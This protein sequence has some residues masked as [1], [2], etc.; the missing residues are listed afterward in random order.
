MTPI[1]KA[2]NTESVMSV[3][4]RHHRFR[5]W[6]IWTTHRHLQI[7]LK[8]DRRLRVGTT[9]YEEPVLYISKR[10]N[11]SISWLR[12]IARSYYKT[13]YATLKH[14]PGL[15]WLD[16]TG[17]LSR[18]CVILGRWLSS[19]VIIVLNTLRTRQIGHH[20]T[21]DIVRFV[22]CHE[23]CCILIQIALLNFKGIWI[24]EHAIV[25]IRNVTIRRILGGLDRDTVI[26]SPLPWYFFCPGSADDMIWSVARNFFVM[27]A[28]FTRITRLLSM[29][30]VFPLQV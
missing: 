17:H 27:K 29:S 3:S 11:H 24:F 10:C 18:P 19:E 7:T 2:S 15:F 9:A 28:V 26:L 4:W 8:C 14:T 20:F 25:R 5:H 22:F 6:P 30:R 1:T 21:D 12:D 23:N 16:G 13:S